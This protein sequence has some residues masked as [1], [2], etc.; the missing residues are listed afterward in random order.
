MKHYEQQYEL[1]YSDPEKIKKKINLEKVSFLDNIPSDINKYIELQRKTY[2]DFQTA[3]FDFIVKE[4]WLRRRFSYYGHYKIIPDGKNF[5]GTFQVDR[6]YTFFLRN[7]VGTDHRLYSNDWRLLPR[8]SRYLDIF[9]PHF[10][11]GDPFK[12]P[13]D[14][15][16]P[17]TY[18]NLEC[19][20][21]VY[22]MPEKMELIEHGENSKM[23]FSIF[24]DYVINYISC[25]N[26]EHG[27]TY[28]FRMMHDRFLGNYISLNFPEKNVSKK[29][30]KRT[31]KRK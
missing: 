14:F 28:K 11:L 13:D 19:L 22:Q 25:Y 18:M 10:E 4:S 30:K 16:Y 20:Y 24:V 1:I 3:I 5:T 12:N 21:L 23:S 26:E 9:F 17:Y 6:A 31:Y 27:N 29:K 15:K 8:L 2:N 7:Y